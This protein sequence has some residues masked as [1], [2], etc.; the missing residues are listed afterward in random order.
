MRAR[1]VLLV[2]A[3]TLAATMASAS[4]MSSCFGQTIGDGV[5]RLSVRQAGALTALINADTACGFASEAARASETV[6]GDPGDLGRSKVTVRGCAIDVVAL[7]LESCSGVTFVTGKLV[8]DAVRT[9]QGTVTGIADAAILPAGPDAVAIDVT[10]QVDSLRVVDD[11][12]DHVMTQTGGTFTYTARPRLAADAEQ[13]LCAVATSHVRFAPLVMTNARVTLDTAELDVSAHIGSMSVEATNGVVGDSE[14]E[15]AGSVTVDGVTQHVA[16]A[17]S[18]TYDRASFDASFTCNERL[19]VPVDF[20]CGTPTKL[21]AGGAA[22]LAVK[23]IG[24]IGALMQQDEVCGFAG[25][26]P[27]VI[28]ADAD[29]DTRGTAVWRSVDCPVTTSAGTLLVTASMSL[30]G[31]LTGDALTPVIPERSDGVIL[32]I[33]EAHGAFIVETEAASLL[34]AN[35]MLSGTARPRLAVGESGI[36]TVATAHASV[37][38]NIARADATLI[39]GA[40]RLPVT[41][42]QL[43]V[44]AVNGRAENG[45]TNH[46]EGS[47]VVDGELVSLGAQEELVTGFNDAAFDALVNE[48]PNIRAPAS[49]ECD[50]R[51]FLGLQ[52][53]RLLISNTGDLAARLG[54]DA[55]CGFGGG[56]GALLNPDDVVDLGDGTWRS[57]IVT[58]G[59]A[60]AGAS[61]QN[62]LAETSEPIGVATF[63]ASLFITGLHVPFTQIVVPDTP[64]STRIVIERA[65]LDAA[66]KRNFSDDGA[67]GPAHVVATGVVS[68]TIEPSLAGRALAVFD[69][70]TPVAHIALSSERL[71]VTLFLTAVGDV[72]LPLVLEEIDLVANNGP[73]GDDTVDIENSIEGSLVIDG[74]RV[75]IARGTVLVPGQTPSSFDASYVCGDVDEAIG[76]D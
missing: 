57:T 24:N 63:D 40:L 16:R 17:L 9:L 45:M 55:Q 32:A 68:A 12:D 14:N 58:E 21:V 56:L 38:A 65:Q 23:A 19:A 61:T 76:R 62:C 4:C 8:V 18:D 54:D 41:L 25:R 20:D 43:A 30:R 59:C 66:G 10:A 42:E 75:D 31:R 48:T 72:A 39:K 35:A 50:P 46:I 36:C 37:E 13:G 7:P 49:F 33:E 64:R 11:G 51:A 29:S 34:L 60:I 44:R 26:G 47:L 74:R 5:A 73:A 52:A 3:V 22:R 1:V 69:V 15:V 28:V 2:S 70:A 27:D 67:P 6:E 71:D 53:A